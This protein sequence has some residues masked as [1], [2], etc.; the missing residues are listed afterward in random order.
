MAANKKMI[1]FDGG[2]LNNE[3]RYVH[4]DTV[5]YGHDYKKS[6]KKFNDI[7]CFVHKDLETDSKE[8]PK[9]LTNGTH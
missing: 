6:S 5:A 7:E 3:F 9:D 2:P 4:K 8:E 1:M